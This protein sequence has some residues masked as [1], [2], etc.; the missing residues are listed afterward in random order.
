[1]EA[2]IIPGVQ[3]PHWRPCASWKAC[4]IGCHTPFSVMPLTVVISCPSACTARTVHDLTDSPSMWTV[5]APQL[6]VLHPACTPP[7]LRF[8]LRWCSNSNLGSTSATWALPSTVIWILRNPLSFPENGLSVCTTCPKFTF[9]RLSPG[10]CQRI[11]KRRLSPRYSAV[12]LPFPLSSRK[13]AQ[14]STA[15]FFV[16]FKGCFDLS[17][18]HRHDREPRRCSNSSAIVRRTSS[19]CAWLRWV[20]SCLCGRV[21]PRG[22]RMNGGRT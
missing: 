4:C 19:A 1:M 14:S 2:M 17:T 16:H 12:L 5:Q 13:C 9:Y 22:N 10:R 18:S 21:C 7:I 3:Y 20:A 15:A 11:Y 6:V 8:S